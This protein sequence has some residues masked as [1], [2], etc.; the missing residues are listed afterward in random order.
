MTTRTEHATAIEHEVG[1][2]VR[3]LVPQRSAKVLSAD[4]V[5]ALR[6]HQAALLTARAHLSRAIEINGQLLQAAGAE[7]A[8]IR[9]LEDLP[10]TTAATLTDELR[11]VR[12]KRRGH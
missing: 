11:R 7:G 10:R 12:S 3:A 1:I 9:T 4:N 2:A 8:G 5:A 6:A